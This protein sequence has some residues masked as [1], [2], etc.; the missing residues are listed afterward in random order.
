[1]TIKYTDPTLVSEYRRT[2]VPRGGQ[3]ATGYGSKIPTAYMLRYA[4]RWYRVYVMQYSN[5]GTAY[6]LVKGEQLILD[7]DTEHRLEG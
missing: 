6:I 2:S 4:G 5:S 1:M 7:I 3:T